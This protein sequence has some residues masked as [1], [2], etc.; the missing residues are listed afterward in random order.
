MV[1]THS[2]VSLPLLR[3]A[4]NHSD[5]GVVAIFTK[6][7]HLNGGHWPSKLINAEF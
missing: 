7:T 2:P 4:S 3:E 5:V 1:G 6:G